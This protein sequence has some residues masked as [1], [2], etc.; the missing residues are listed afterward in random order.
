[1]NTAALISAVRS[2]LC[3][4]WQF[5][6]RCCTYLTSRWRCVLFCVCQ[7]ICFFFIL[8]SYSLYHYFILCYFLP[9]K[10]KND[11]RLGQKVISYSFNFW[12]LPH[13]ATFRFNILVLFCFFSGG[14]NT[15]TL[16]LIWC[17]V[18]LVLF[19]STKICNLFIISIYL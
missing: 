19:I 17:G 13:I 15:V 14:A 2:N 4:D 3:W 8:L 12:T 1:M 9:E 7:F 18:I 6:G 10:H 16:V 5:D 11:T